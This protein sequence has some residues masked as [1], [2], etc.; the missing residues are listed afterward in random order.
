MMSLIS[1]HER[2]GVIKMADDEIKK[3]KKA[4]ANN[5][6]KLRNDFGLQQTDLA[7]IADV[8]ALSVRG[9]ESRSRN[10][11]FPLKMRIVNALSKVS[12]EKSKGP[13]TFA[14]VYPNDEPPANDNDGD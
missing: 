6:W 3:K 11:S 7:K 13:L 2:S 12:E 14:D 4:K 9:T 8:S 1:A 5:V 10:L